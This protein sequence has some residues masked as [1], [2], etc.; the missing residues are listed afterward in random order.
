[1]NQRPAQPAT[2]AMRRILASHQRH[3]LDYDY[4]YAVVSRRSKGLS[5]GVNLN[6][7]KACNFDCPY[8]LVDRS[9]A[10]SRRDVDLAQLRSELDRMLTV[11]ANGEIWQH[12]RFAGVE[13]AYRRVNDIAFSGDG[14]P[15][16][17]AHFDEAVRM[18]VELRDSHALADLK[19][20]VITN[21]TAL[22]R[23][24]VREAIAMFDCER[25][26]VWAKLDAGTEPYYQYVDRTKVPFQKVLDNI[27]D[28]GQSRPLI[29]QSIFV[30]MHGKP[31]D[32]AEFDAYVDRLTT[33]IAQGCRIQAVHMYTLARPPAE[34]YVTALDLDHLERLADIARQHLGSVPVEVFGAVS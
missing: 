30:K 27:R 29:I 24:R 25:D 32:A 14:E 15:T 26:E 9:V 11:A 23:P 7:D 12:E 31:I 21:A 3:W 2:A 19:L 20:I 8:C 5:I 10:P 17:Y 22:H 1:M 33:L 13:P 28:C 16:V 18:A 4:V 34:S 6:P